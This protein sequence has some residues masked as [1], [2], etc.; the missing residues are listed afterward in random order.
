MGG[1]QRR[2]AEFGDDV[3]VRDLACNN[4]CGD[5]S[6]EIL[7]S[8]IDSDGPAIPRPWIESRGGQ[9]NISDGVSAEQAL[10]CVIPQGV[11][12]CGFESPLGSSYLALVRMRSTQEESYGFIRPS[13]SVLVIVVSD[14]VDCSYNKDWS[15]IFDAEGN[16]AFWSDP[17]E[18]Y[19]TSAVCWNAGV[20]CRGDPSGYTRGVRVRSLD[21]LRGFARRRLPVRVW[22]RPG[23]R[24][25]ERLLGGAA[26]PHVRGR[27]GH[28]RTHGLDLP[29]RLRG[30]VDPDGP[31]PSSMAAANP[32]RPWARRK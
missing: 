12:G 7:P 18:P 29:R 4:L 25:R 5:T 11:N 14:E 22:D 23:V 21:R 2:L 6:F 16:R 32:A 31:P 17:S 1:A 27:R 10:R 24:D 13:S 26:G 3:D 28:G 9:T 30:C 15:E 20:E 8:T 19:P